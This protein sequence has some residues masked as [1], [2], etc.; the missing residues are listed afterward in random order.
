M[1]FEKLITQTVET[2]SEVGMIH[3]D[4]TFLFEEAVWQVQ[5]KYFDAENNEFEM[6][7][8]AKISHK[9]MHWLNEGY[10]RVHTKEPHDFFNFYEITPFGKETDFTNW[11]SY[12]PSMGLLKGKY[13]IID[14]TIISSFKSEYS[15]Y[16]GV[17]YL[18][19]TDSA[20]Y[21]NRG[22]SFRGEKKL[23]SWSLTLKKI[24][25]NIRFLV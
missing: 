8:M 2:Y 23:A 1:Y 15:S 18:K 10:M 19:K 4:H 21:Q 13:M 14:D 25:D 9:Q 17:E 3:T 12:N 11:E 20:T 7:G 16:S 22:F 6:D 5:G 24:V